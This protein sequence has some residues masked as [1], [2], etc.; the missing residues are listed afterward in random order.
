MTR[1]AQYESNDQEIGVVDGAGLV[2][3]LTMSGE[4]AIMVRYQSHVSVFRATVPLGVP[5][6]AY[7][8]EPKTVVDQYTRGQV[9]GTG[10][11][12]LRIVF[13]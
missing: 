10:P 8:F 13:G 6:P 11:R 4:A 2:R 12:A 9:E 5:I 7:T 3:T 1:R